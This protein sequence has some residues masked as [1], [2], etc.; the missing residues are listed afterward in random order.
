[1]SNDNEKSKSTSIVLMKENIYYAAIN[2]VRS[3]VILIS[4]NNETEYNSLSSNVEYIDIIGIL[5]VV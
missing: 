4:L 5:R 3:T 1:M 2:S